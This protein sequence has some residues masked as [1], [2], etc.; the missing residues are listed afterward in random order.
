MNSASYREVHSPART[1]GV[2]IALRR[3]FGAG[4]GTDD[5]L[6]LLKQLDLKTAS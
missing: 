6:D 4:E 5:F 2:G 1:D 3:A